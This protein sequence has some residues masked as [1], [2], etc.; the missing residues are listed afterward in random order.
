L[1]DPEDGPVAA[2]REAVGCAS[3]ANAIYPDPRP[4][5]CIAPTAGTRGVTVDGIAVSAGQVRPAV[6]AE[7]SGFCVPVGLING[8]G[9][10]ISLGPGNF[11]LVA[12][13]GRQ[14]PFDKEGDYRLP[15]RAL[16]TS[17]S[18]TGLLC[19]SSTQRPLHLIFSAGPFGRTRA[20]FPL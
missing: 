5:D 4:S 17:R 15:T 9:T 7:A 8:L 16:A 3:A 14:V 2:G 1:Q 12:A 20:V 19:W 13:N 18:S 6:V 11:R 10:S